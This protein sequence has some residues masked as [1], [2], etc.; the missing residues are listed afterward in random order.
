MTIYTAIAAKELGTGQ[1]VNGL[2][3]RAWIEGAYTVSPD[4]RKVRAFTKR[5]G[6]L[7]AA[8][9]WADFCNEHFL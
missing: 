8:Q 1:S 4:G 2:G 6:G 3:K 9:K 5:E 7:E